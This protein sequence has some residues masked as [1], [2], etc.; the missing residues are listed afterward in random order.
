MNV[1]YSTNYYG[2]EQPKPQAV[3]P[4]VL[5]ER[6]HPLEPVVSWPVAE[7]NRGR[8]AGVYWKTHPDE[9]FP[10]AEI[11]VWIGSNF[12]IYAPDLVERCVDE[13]GDDDLVV[14]RHPWRDDIFEEQAESHP[15]PKY[16]GQ[17]TLEQVNTYVLA[18]HPVQWGLAHGGFLVRRNNERANAFSHR[19]WAEIARWSI[20][21]Q[22]SLPHVLR[23]SDLKWHWWPTGPVGRSTR[24]SGALR[25][26]QIGKA[27]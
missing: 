7:H 13:L 8:V 2:Y 9:A 16:D 1:L 11:T 18:G 26:G 10:D 14:M 6:T 27:A 24:F 4:I 22:L 25:Y 20:Q 15:N 17:P 3:H 21:D 5:D 12:D 23:T 19:W